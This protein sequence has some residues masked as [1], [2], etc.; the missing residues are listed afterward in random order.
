[1]AVT[2]LQIPKEQ[3]YDNMLVSSVPFEEMNEETG[4]MV[5][6]IAVTWQAVD[7]V[8]APTGHPEVSAHEGVEEK[9][10]TELREQSANMG[11]LVTNWSSN[12]EWNPSGY[13]KIIEVEDT[14]KED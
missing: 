7:D 4:K 9:F 10:H 6:G 2:G 8:L 3:E 14:K 5:I 1:M 13:Q 12:P 11:H